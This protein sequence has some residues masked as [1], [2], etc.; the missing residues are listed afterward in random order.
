[1]WSVSSDKNYIAGCMREENWSQLTVSTTE[2]KIG[3]M[4]LETQNNKNTT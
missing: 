2:K 3:Q 1:M 4:F